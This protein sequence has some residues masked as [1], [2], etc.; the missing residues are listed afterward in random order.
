MVTQTPRSGIDRSRDKL[1]APGPDRAGNYR[2]LLGSRLAHGLP[3]L[4]L[5]MHWPVPRP[6]ALRSRLVATALVVAAAILA[7]SAYSV[8]SLLDVLPMTVAIYATWLGWLQLVHGVAAV[9]LWRRRHALSTRA[10]ATALYWGGLA[11]WYWLPAP[12]YYLLTMNIDEL[13]LKWTAFAFFWEVPVVGGAFVL[14]AQ[15]LFPLRRPSAGRDPARAYRA[16]TRYPSVVAALLFGFTL[17]GYAIGA[18]QL[19]VFAAL[20]LVEQA[21]NV[22]HGLVISLLLAVFYHLALD[23]VLEPL[24]ARLAREASLGSL[25]ARTV[26]GRILGVSLAV[27]VSGFALISLFVLQ[28]FQGMVRESASTTLA[29]DLPGLAAAPATAGRLGHFADW[30]E[31]GRLLLLRPGESLPAAEF[32]PAT[33]RRVGAGGTA[34]VHDTREDLKVVGVVDAPRLG[35]RLVGVVR[36]TDGY[37]PLMTAARLLGIAGGCVLIVTVGM[38]VFASRASTQAVRA[39]SSAVRRVEAG[40]VDAAVLRLDTGDEIGELSAVIERYV[41]QS[42]DLRDTLEE[43]VR[44]KTQRLEALHHIDRSILAAESVDAIAR[45]ALPRLRQ[46]VPYQWG[47]V[48]LF[49]PGHAQARLLVIDGDGG[50]AEGARLPVGEVPQR[51]LEAAAPSLISAPLVASGDTIGLLCIARAEVDAFDRDQAEIVSE[52]ATQLAVAIHQ[53][54]LRAALDAQQQRLQAVVEHMPEG[55]VLLER[56]GRTALANPMARAHLAAVATTSAAGEVTAVGSLS[57]ERL[58]AGP[59]IEPREITAATGRVFQVAARRLAGGQGAVVVIRD[60]TREREAQHIAQQQARLASVGQLAAGIAHDFNNILMTI[61]NSAELGLRKQTDA[62]FVRGRLGVIVE[63]GERAAALVRQI[64]DFSRQSMPSLETVD[65][66]Q[67]LA[68]TIGLLERTLPESISIGVE[69]AGGPFLISADPN[70]LTQVLTNLAVNARDVMPLGGELRFHLGREHR[71]GA[72]VDSG[73]GPGQWVVLTVS[74]TGAGMP[75]EIRERIFDPFFTTKAPGRG[76]GLGLSQAYGIVTEHRGHIT[77]ES[78]PGQGTRFAL[79]LPSLPDDPGTAEAQAGLELVRGSGEMLLVV[80]D[81]ALVRQTLAHILADLNY[82]TL[83]AS[84]AEN[85]LELHAAH[86]GE[87]A[88]VLTDLVMPGMGGLGLVRTLRE[89]HVRVPVVMMSGYVGDS[90]RVNVEGV[91]A[92]VEKPVMARR[93]GVVIQE[94]LSA[95]CSPR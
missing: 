3:S 36:L 45:G 30:G 38:L 16:I 93:L 86:A 6:F 19:R 61:V 88:L 43:K 52:V 40:E 68:Q 4:L 28:A 47:A 95:D 92:W 25:V 82:R 85:A 5:E 22:A 70:Q 18:L 29:H 10:K 72:A 31:G 83:T 78:R 11:F 62:P 34:I 13:Q 57:L 63:Q 24:R 50:P 15:R 76:T 7:P 23:R 59:E 42:R 17:A 90:T 20:P 33:R 89:R 71:A 39:L 84:S 79:Y 87:V 35:G 21:K 12:I 14:A 75:P 46:I 51:L 65:L 56:D 58:L 48:V 54:Q 81:E 44:A 64:L 80:E 91:L 41:R 1:T 55:V 66:G 32:S 49:E 77:V 2:S 8:L 67:L 53:A 9:A 60:V 27:A 94:A 37:G 26:A 73:P 74:D 69:A